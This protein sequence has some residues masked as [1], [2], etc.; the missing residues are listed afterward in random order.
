MK[1]HVPVLSRLPLIAVVAFTLAVGGLVGRA[2]PV[3][4]TDNSIV[5]DTLDGGLI[6]GDGKCSLQEAISNANG[7]NDAFADCASGTGLTDVITFSGIKGTIKLTAGLSLG[8]GSLRI[9][10]DQKITLSLAR[11]VGGTVVI[12]N[13]LDA[14]LDGLTIAGGSGSTG[15]GIVNQGGLMARNATIANNTATTVG[16]G[17]YNTGV[18]FVDNS[19]ISANAAASAGA[20]IFNMGTLTMKDST[21]NRNKTTGEGGG[22]ANMSPGVLAFQGNNT[23]SHNTA[24]SGGG[25]IFNNSGTFTL[26]TGATITYK[27]NKPDDCLCP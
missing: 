9:E 16:G 4:A 22:I 15:G 17:I 21:F 1:I 20:G 7:D 8:G 27:G 19:T 25:G 6:N 13:A 10:G 2:A 11:G 12:N 3:L 23:V 18:L 24:G 5:V 14:T 26:A